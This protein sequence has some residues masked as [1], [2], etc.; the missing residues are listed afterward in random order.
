MNQFDGDSVELGT[1]VRFTLQWV[2]LMSGRRI[3]VALGIRES[4][5]LT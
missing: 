4:K 1:A 2:R 5:L 3:I